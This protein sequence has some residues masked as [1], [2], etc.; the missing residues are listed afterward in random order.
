MLTDTFG[1][2]LKAT[3][4]IKNMTQLELSKRLELSKAT[5]SA[6]EQVA[7]YPSIETL[8]KICN[9]LDVSADFLLGLSDNL[10]FEMGGLTNEQRNSV[11]QFI[12]TIEK[13]NRI[14]GK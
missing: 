1:E 3:R 13:A 11:L 2:R 10:T 14:I 5:I 6:Y 8:V 12:S 4:K 9:I 7:S